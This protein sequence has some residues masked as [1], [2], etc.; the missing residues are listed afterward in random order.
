MSVPFLRVLLDDSDV[1][2]CGHHLYAVVSMRTFSMYARIYRLADLDE[3]VVILGF[4]R[5]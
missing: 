2:L 4:G 3:C 1:L 5:E